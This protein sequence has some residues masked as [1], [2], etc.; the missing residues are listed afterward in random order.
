NEILEKETES[1]LEDDLSERQP[2]DPV[3]HQG[4]VTATE[5][6]DEPLVAAFEEQAPASPKESPQT[7]HEPKL[8]LLGNIKVVTPEGEL[9]DRHAALLAILKISQEPVSPQQISE[10]LWP[11]DE[12]QGQT[13]RT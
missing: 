10:L 4:Q 5:V 9:T 12:A 1:N 3:D 6:D 11:G 13:A 7:S 8:Q 2:G